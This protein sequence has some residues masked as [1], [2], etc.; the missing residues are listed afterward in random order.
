MMKKRTVTK[1]AD[2]APTGMLDAYT[3]GPANNAM[4][5]SAKFKEGY[6][7][8]GKGKQKNIPKK[9]ETEED[10]ELKEEAEVVFFKKCI[11]EFFERMFCSRRRTPGRR[12]WSSPGTSWRWS[13]CLFLRRYSSS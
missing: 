4:S 6:K 11:L 3:E 2:V 12:T 1:R 10:P 5:D 8:K 7:K 9:V 13:R